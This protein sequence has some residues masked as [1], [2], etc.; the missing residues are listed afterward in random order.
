MPGNTTIDRF[1]LFYAGISFLAMFYWLII[2]IYSKRRNYLILIAVTAGAVIYYLNAFGIILQYPKAD[3]VLIAFL[4]MTFFV[5]ASELN[6]FRKNLSTFTFYVY[7][8]ISAFTVIFLLLSPL[9]LKWQT[10]V[11]ISCLLIILSI[12]VVQYLFAYLWLWK[13][14]PTARFAFFVYL[15]SMIGSIIYFL[16]RIKIL[17]SELKISG[18]VGMTIF[19]L[20]IFYGMVTYV[21]ALRKKR[22]KEHLEKEELIKQQNI[23]LKQKV[24]ERTRELEIERKRSEELLIHASQKQMAELEL[25]SLRA[26]LNPHFMFNSLNAI[27]ELILKEDFEN[28]HTY[29]AKF[30]KLLRMLLENSEIPFTPLQKEIDFVELYLSLERLR[31]PD[32][33]FSITTDPFIN[34]EETLIPTMILQPYVENALWHGLSHKTSN[35]NLELNIKRKDG[36]VIYDVK[37]NGV[38]RKRAAELKSLYRKKHKSKGMELLAKRFKLLRDEFGSDIKS[39]VRDVMN[40]GEV[41][42]TIVSIIVPDSLSY[43]I[44]NELYDTYNYH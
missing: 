44:K 19:L 8:S 18:P 2:F 29:L 24:A 37:D 33:H 21:I 26:R 7:V 11:T 5:L 6:G 34:I 22:E 41:A 39:E 14:Q 28:A 35:R 9:F 32:L 38:G 42:G 40:N 4:T 15:P 36:I 16:S 17:P 25:Q 31:L 20:L 3:H 12:I 23:L 1:L 13:R 27:Q 30:A 10:A 43:N